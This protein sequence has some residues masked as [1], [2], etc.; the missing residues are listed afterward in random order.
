MCHLCQ[1]FPWLVLKFY[2]ILPP[3]ELQGQHAPLPSQL[4]RA[5]MKERLKQEKIEAK[6]ARKEEM[7]RQ[8]EAEKMRR[9]EERERVSV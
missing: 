6:E 3:A 2:C 4:D 7:R 9:K 1:T 8:I 5:L